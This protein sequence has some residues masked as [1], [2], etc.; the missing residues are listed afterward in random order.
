MK[1]INQIYN[2]E[3]KKL[4]YVIIGVIIIAIIIIIICYANNKENPNN[5]IES[6]KIINGNDNKTTSKTYESGDLL[7]NPGKGFVLRDS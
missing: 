1:R 7:L 5:I 3:R 2:V 4:K 6:I